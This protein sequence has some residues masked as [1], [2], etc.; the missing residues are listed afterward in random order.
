VG[1]VGLG[2]GLFAASCTTP[3]PFT[4]AQNTHCRM[5]DVLGICTA[6]G[7]CAYPFDECDTGWRYPVGAPDG[8]GG[9]CAP[10]PPDGTTSTGVDSQG[11]DSTTTTTT[12][13]LTT[14][15]DTTDGTTTVPNPTTAVG[16]TSGDPT[17]TE[18]EA[19]EDATPNDDLA[20][21]PEVALQPCM[22]TVNDTIDADLGDDWLWFTV[23][24]A[25]GGTFGLAG[26]GL[27]I[28]AEVCIFADCDALDAE[29]CDREDD[30]V[31]YDG[32]S[33]CCSVP[34][35]GAA[36]VTFQSRD[37]API[38]QYFTVVTSYPGAAPACTP[39]TLYFA[40]Q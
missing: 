1:A 19:C 26:A 16:S 13:T 21:A 9:T 24:V 29:F 30:F 35:E 36:S 20:T 31:T 17:G 15:T 3:A 40:V 14:T 27:N 23:P 34:G 25:C 8:L 6:H 2:L 33:G 37:C 4:C 5:G 28:D 10:P 32:L 22:A 7:H 39:Y 38:D 11:S 12:T 18:G